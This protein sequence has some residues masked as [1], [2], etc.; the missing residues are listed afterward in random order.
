MTA[1]PLRTRMNCVYP[2]AASPRPLRALWTRWAGVASWWGADT[3][4]QVMR[5]SGHQKLELLRYVRTASRE[6]AGSPPTAHRGSFASSPSYQARL[7]PDG[8]AFSFDS[9]SGG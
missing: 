4:R 8:Y 5:A 7:Q 6:V 3:V 1:D 9:P 2:A